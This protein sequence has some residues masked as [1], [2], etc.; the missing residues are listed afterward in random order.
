R[1][2]GGSFSTREIFIEDIL[3]ASASFSIDNPAV[4]VSGDDLAYILYTSGS[5]GKPKGVLIRHYNVVNMLCSLLEMP[6]I[7]QADVLLAV[8]TISFDIAVVEMFL[9]LIAGATIVLADANVVRNGRELLQVVKEQQITIM[10]ATPATYKMMLAAG[11]EQ[12]LPLKVLCGGEPMTKDLADKLLARC[13]SLFN[14]YGPTETTVYSI[15]KQIFSTDEIITIGNPINNTQVYILDENLNA[16][17]EGAT[18]EIHIAGEGVGSGYLH[19]P[20]LTAEKFIKNPFDEYG[21]TMYKTGDL[22]KFLFNGE[23]QCFGRIDRQIKLRGFRIEPGEIENAIMKLTRF[24]EAIVTAKQDKNSH[25]VLVAYVVCKEATDEN[26]FLA[27]V[28]KAKEQLKAE[29]PAYMVPDHFINLVQ[30]PLLP[31]GKIDYNS[32]PEPFFAIVNSNVEV[33][34]TGTEKLVSEVWSEFLHIKNIG[35]DDNFFLLGGHSMIA[36]EVMMRLEKETGIKLPLSSLFEYPT[37]KK[38]AMLL[39]ADNKET[40]WKSLV[41]I[42]PGGNKMPV[43]IIHGSGSNILNFSSFAQHMDDEQPVYGLQAKGLAGSDEPSSNMEEIAAYY[44]NEV[45]KHNPDGPYAIAGYSFGGYVA[46]EMARQLK[47]LG[48]EVKLL[49]MLDT[50][51]EQH[52]TDKSTLYKTSHKIIR[53]FKKAVWIISR[54]IEEPKGTINYQ[55]SY[56]SNKINIISVKL[57][58][59]K[60]EKPDGYLLELNRISEQNDMAYYNYRLQPFDGKIDLFKAKERVYF[61]DDFKYLGWKKYAQQG[62]KVYEVPGDHRTMLYPPNDK[63]FAR[64]LQKALDN[65][66][67]LIANI[68]AGAFL[69][70]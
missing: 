30:L 15:G 40:I 21:G 70:L 34:F 39:Q 27:T 22:G 24:K 42:K 33:K 31:N 68:T 45:L 47:L 10:Q 53:Q 37:I 14:M 52:L 25:Q 38:F 28:A 1:K 26:K 35:I 13:G 60:E 32:L 5:T 54:L 62:V 7:S 58:F 43:Y 57:G 19:L 36:V 56:L 2:Y 8:T 67:L 16:V 63:I 59:V 6:G 51:A 65:C 11:W 20:E 4:K 49:A 55:L 50:N 46:V 17:A 48:K 61:I 66:L 23:V 69:M 3:S 41:P 64:V 9:P 12:P 29:L 18:G 44:I